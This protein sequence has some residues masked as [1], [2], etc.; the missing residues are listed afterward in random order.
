MHASYD[1]M[2]PFTD[3]WNMLGLYVNTYWDIQ[4]TFVGF[5]SC[6]LYVNED[7][8][9]RCLSWKGNEIKQHSGVPLVYLEPFYMVHGWC[10]LEFANFYFK[11][12][13]KEQGKNIF[14]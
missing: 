7:M 10:L 3:I 13:E 11:P 5:L 12:I 1:S 2:L 9:S 4:L 8:V 6:I 14:K